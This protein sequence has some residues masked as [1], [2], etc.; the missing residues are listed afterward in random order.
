MRAPFLFWLRSMSKRNRLRKANRRINLQAAA[1][2]EPLRL[3]AEQPVEFQAAAGDAKLPTF[4]MTA[5]TGGKMR[6]R[7]FTTP[8]V[9]D[10]ARTMVASGDRPFL[11]NHDPTQIVGHGTISVEQNSI[12]AEGTMSG[13]GG[14]A[15]GV[16]ASALNGFPW[17]ASIGADVGKLEFI[18]AGKQVTVNG[19][20]FNGPLYVA[21][22]STIYESS[23]VSLAGDNRSSATVAASLGDQAMNEFE[24]WLTAKGF[25][26][27]TLSDTAK[28]TLKATFEAEKNPPPKV[29]A[30][31]DESDDDVKKYRA[32]IAAENNR[33]KS[34]QKICAEYDGVKFKANGTEVDL[35]AHAIAEGWDADKTELYA[36]RKSRPAAAIHSRSH[37][38][39]CNIQALQGAMILRAGYDLDSKIF[40]TQQAQA[41][42]LPGWIRAGLNT[43]QRQKA[44]EASWRYRDMSMFD[45]ALQAIRLDGKDIPTGSRNDVLEAAFSG[46]SLTNVFT[47]NVNTVILATYMGA[48]DTTGGWVSEQDVADF[49]SN[50]RPRMVV[51]PNLA[52]LPPGQEADHVTRSDLAE[53]YKIYRYAKQFVVD[54]Q[55]FINDSFG[56]MN[57]TPVQMG[58]AAARLRPDLVYYLL[59]S[60]PTLAADSVVLFHSSHSNLNTTATF[61]ATTL[62]T[63][64]RYIELQTENSVNLN[65]R[66]SHLIVPPALK[67]SAAELINSSTILYGGDD[68]AVRGTLNTINSEE[69]LTLVCDAR[70]E[71]GVTDPKSGT[72]ASGS[73]TTWFMASNMGHTIEV[74]YLRG[75]GRAPQVRPFTLSQGKWGMG[76]DVKHDIGGQVLDYRG[77]SKNTA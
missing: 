48:G 43:E 10:L 20:T 46:S 54:E 6:P 68:E 47:T 38:A 67:H 77:L 61:T 15:E 32:E 49:K 19:R 59:M 28:A 45:V 58:L 24:K 44:M 13:V 7:G 17:K 57:D 40:Q 50:E 69:N 2:N 12:K 71:N 3:E 73:A 16:R 41:M 70:L 36:L 1:L 18:E 76:W 37:D 30:S 26:L 21:R 42:K 60:N 5:Y 23:F 64:I 63:A 35:A 25:E 29:E 65:L 8:V 72:T 14:A 4:K 62:K 39:D 66:A 56:A 27:A 34:I 53:S 52:K 74:G 22:D 11:F 55:D 33:V 75:T 9:V 51:G 31:A